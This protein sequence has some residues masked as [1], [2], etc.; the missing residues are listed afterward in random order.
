M[1]PWSATFFHLRFTVWGFKGIGVFP[2]LTK[3]PSISRSRLSGFKGT[4][5][6]EVTAGGSFHLASA[7]R[8]GRLVHR[9][10]R[11]L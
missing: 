10:L 6:V 2:E 9:K 11:Y 5:V 8:G 4:G 7:N 1:G 3:R